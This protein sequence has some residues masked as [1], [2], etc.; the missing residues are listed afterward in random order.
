M[1]KKLWEKWPDMTL[2]IQ[3][4]AEEAFKQ[5]YTAM[6]GVQFY[7]ECYSS[8]NAQSNYDKHGKSNNCVSGVGKDRANFVYRIKG[9]F[10]LLSLTKMIWLMQIDRNY[11][12]LIDPNMLRLGYFNKFSWS[13]VVEDCG[14]DWQQT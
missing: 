12:A 2:V 4:C 14:S 10:F 6:F 7:G 11:I 1:G 3:L 8:K 9:E 13:V 5:G